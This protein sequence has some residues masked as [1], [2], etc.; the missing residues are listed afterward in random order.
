MFLPWFLLSAFVKGS[1]IILTNNIELIHLGDAL[2][3]PLGYVLRKIFRV[4][5]I[6]TVHGLDVVFKFKPYQMIIPRFMKRLDK[7]ICVSEQTKQ[8][9]L[10]RGIPQWKTIVIPNGITI[11]NHHT[12]LSSYSHANNRKEIEKVINQNLNGKTILLTVGRLVKRKGVN[13]FVREILPRILETE[14][15]IIYFVVGSGSEQNAIEQSIEE[16]KLHNQVFLFG[17]VDKDLLDSVYSIADIFVMPNIP[18]E[19]DMEG[20]GIV[21]LEANLAGLPV[22]ASDLEGIK[23]AVIHEENGYLV[24]TKDREKFVSTII[25]LIRDPSYREELGNKARQF[26]ICNYSWE[27]IGVRYL[28]EFKTIIKTR[29]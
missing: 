15:D 6:A 10:V 13:Y 19:G 26:V 12:K 9:V 3:S 22:V 2:L 27:H 17:R 24:G 21:A 20:F 14:K 18:I 11:R 8:Q 28:K 7:I 5:V 1:W 29:C 25:N 4:P 16:L 23:D